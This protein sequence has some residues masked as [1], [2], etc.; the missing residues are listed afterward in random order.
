MMNRLAA[1][2]GA[3]ALVSACASGR[4]AEFSVGVITSSSNPAAQRE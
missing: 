3:V 1:L 4:R 2:L